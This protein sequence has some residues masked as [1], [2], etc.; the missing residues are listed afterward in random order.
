MWTTYTLYSY[1]PD[2]DAKAGYDGR[3]KQFW[4]L[5]QE[6]VHGTV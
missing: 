1:S 2:S 5:E 3:L 6:E 4:R